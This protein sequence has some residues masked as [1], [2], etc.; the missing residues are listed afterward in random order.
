MGG[1]HPWNTLLERTFTPEE[2]A[3]IEREG[4]KIA[5]DNRRRRKPRAGRS[6]PPRSQRR[7]HRPA[8]GDQ[9][10]QPTLRTC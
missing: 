5:A 10:T 1:H 2:H 3:E 6:S 4:T 7:P 8:D 9:W